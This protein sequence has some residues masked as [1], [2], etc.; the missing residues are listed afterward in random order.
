MSGLL[1]GKVVVVTGGASGIGR[2]TSLRCARE[3][4]KVVIGDVRDAP[5]EGG[6]RATSAGA[7]IS[8]P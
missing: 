4:A 2:G 1:D 5:R 3:G 7:A 6:S 8:S